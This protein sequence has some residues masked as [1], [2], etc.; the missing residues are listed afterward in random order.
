[1]HSGSVPRNVILQ[2]PLPVKAA[3]ITLQ[4]YVVAYVMMVLTEG[5]YNV[6]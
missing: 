4:F 2:I 1:M 6:L 3:V 5:S